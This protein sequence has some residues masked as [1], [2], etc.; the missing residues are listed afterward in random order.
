MTI[1]LLLISSIL[2]VSCPTSTGEILDMLSSR[3]Y[4]LPT[5]L[6][7]SLHNNSTL[8]VKFSE[9]VELLEA[10]SE[11]KAL[12]SPSLGS[13]FSIPLP[14]TLSP[15]EKC[16]V[17][18]TARKENGNTSRISLLLSGRNHNLPSLILNE[19]SVKGTQSSPDRIELYVT[20]SGD[21]AGMKVGGSKWEYTL[22][23]I[24]VTEGDLLLIYWDKPTTKKSWTRDDGK[25]TYVLNASS[26]STLP[27]TEGI[28][29]IREEE[30]GDITDVLVYSEKGEE[31]FMEDEEFSSILSLG[32][33]D[34]EH[35]DS[36]F[37]TSSRVIAR[38]PGAVDSDTAEDFFTTKARNSTF[39]EI[40]TYMPYEE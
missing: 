34:G 11:G 20:E 9:T 30:N 1:I 27:G 39:G 14:R 37:I 22:P 16:R 15:G 13:S 32:L 8:E 36:S 4:S 3:D 2:L 10:T 19:V 7:H 31:A 6:S 5:V 21:T 38:L 18:M 17:S 28:I 23:S 35:F 40:N 29:Y 26:P 24:T 12:I 33:W 25:M